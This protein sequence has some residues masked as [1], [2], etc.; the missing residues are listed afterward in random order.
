M[1][2]K[3]EQ[4][5]PN[6]RRDAGSSVLF[7]Y[8]ALETEILERGNEVK[9]KHK[10]YDIIL[11]DVDGTLLDFLKSEKYALTDSLTHFGLP[12]SDEII[13]T[14]S[15]INEKCWKKLE[16]GEVERSW[17]LVHRFEELFEYLKIEHVDVV[18]FQQHYQ[19]NLG[20]VFYFQD[21]AGKL[22]AELGKD[23]G[24]YIV[25]NGVEATQ[26]RKL[27]LSGIT[28]L[29]DDIFISECIGYEKPNPL[30]FEGCMELIKEKS[31]SMPD[32]ERIL[33]VGDSLTS[34]IKGGNRFGIHSCFY[35]RKSPGGQKETEYPDGIKPDY[36]IHNLWEVKRIIWQNPQIKN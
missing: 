9:E 33:I 36:I 34:D 28:E 8:T 19:Y 10:K 18:E 30:F 27:E 14:Y 6:N 7:L 32:K 1:K 29:V 23:F 31:G 5:L 3:Q 11:W 13:K 24:Q 17:V 20:S 16:R 4:T 35:S 25:T 22:L 26:R 15:G 21:N 12:V 2:M